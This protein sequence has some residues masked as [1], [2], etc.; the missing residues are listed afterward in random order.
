M[1]INTFV[2]MPLRSCLNVRINKELKIPS[3][4]A[5]NVVLK[6]KAKKLCKNKLMALNALLTPPNSV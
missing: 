2:L 4:P 5:K 1:Y 6:D 3:R